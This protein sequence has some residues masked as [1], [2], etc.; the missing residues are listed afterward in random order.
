VKVAARIGVVVVLF[1]CAAG[2]GVDIHR[3]RRQ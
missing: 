2:V 3:F 1:V